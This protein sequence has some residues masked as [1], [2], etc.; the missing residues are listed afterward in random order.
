MVRRVRQEPPSPSPRP[1]SSVAHALESDRQSAKRS[2]DSERRQPT[3]LITT[4]LVFNALFAV[5]NGLDATFLWS[6]ANLPDGL[7]FAEYAHRGAYPLVA[8]AL[9]AGAFVLLTF[10]TSGTAQ[11]HR[12]ARWLV[13]AWIVQNAIL[14]LSSAWR[15]QLYI[16]A[17]ALT[18]LRLAAF[19]WMGLVAAGLIY[20]LI[21]IARHYGNGWLLRINA[22]TAFGLLYV[23]AFLPRDAFIASYNVAHCQQQ[24]GHGPAIDLDYLAEL[25]P[26]ALPALRTLRR[27]PELA[28]GAGLRVS[29]LESEVARDLRDWRG[30]TLQKWRVRHR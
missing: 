16:D 8:T 22:A 26:G 30:V 11:T 29:R 9:L 28:Y 4:L 15:L 25:G 6:G 2:I 1:G 21:R 18:R 23:C 27:N 17:Y 10:Q 20:I 13:Y 19:L 7:T 24:T 12:S 3:V 5:Q 14:T